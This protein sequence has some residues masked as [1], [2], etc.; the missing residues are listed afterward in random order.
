MRSESG[1]VAKRHIELSA[2]GK[3]YLTEESFECFYSNYLRASYFELI[4]KNSV[5]TALQAL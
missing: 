5:N 3:D 2:G 1:A 4:Y